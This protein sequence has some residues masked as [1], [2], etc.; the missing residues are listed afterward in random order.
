MNF[1]KIDKRIIEN[2]T[3]SNFRFNEGKKYSI[4]DLEYITEN[5]QVSLYSILKSQTLNIEYC[6]KYLLNNDNFYS[7]KDIDNNIS[8]QDILFYQKHLKL[9]DFS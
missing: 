9:I 1:E 7:V 6:K 5:C 8:I 4:K 2:W 3:A